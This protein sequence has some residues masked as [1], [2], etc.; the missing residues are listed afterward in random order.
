MTIHYLTAAFAAILVAEALIFAEMKFSKRRSA[1]CKAASLVFAVLFLLAYLWDNDAIYSV[2]DLA[3]IPGV[4]TVGTAGALIL[5]WFTAAAGIFLCL[6]PF[7]KK[8]CPSADLLLVFPVLVFALDAVFLNDFVAAHT[9]AALGAATAR[10]ALLAAEVGF[11]LGYSVFAL[12][13]NIG[14]L[15]AHIKSAGWMAL[16]LVGILLC[17]APNFTLQVLFDPNRY[18]AAKVE[19]LNLYHRLFIYPAAVI[20]IALYLL[21]GKRDLVTKRYVL[22]FYALAGLWN[23]MSLQ[24]FP[25][26]IGLEHVGNLPLHLCNTAL[27]VTPLCLTFKLKRVFY[28]TYFINVFGAFLALTIPNYSTE[29]LSGTVLMASTMHFY[30]PHYQ[31]FFMPLL[32]VALGIFERPRLRQFIW[33]MVGFLFYYV[34]M[35]VLNGWFTNYD[36]GVDFFFINS[37]FV[38]DKLGSWAEQLRNIVVQF[39]IGGLTFTYYPLYQSLYFLVY[40]LL[41]LAMW[42]LYEIAF[43]SVAGWRDLAARRKKIRMDRL[44][45][46]V[47]R[48]QD[49]QGGDTMNETETLSIRGFSKR[50]GTSDVYAV[51][52]VWLDVKGGEI[53]GFL[54]PNG[55]GKSTIIKSIVGIQPITEGSILVCGHD[56]EQESV[57]SKRCIGFV[58]DHYALYEKLTAREYVNYIADL[59]NVPKEERDARMAE[60]VEIF[61]LKKAVDEPISTYSHGMKQ[62]VAIMAA[63][64]HDPKVWILDE[65]LTGLDPN[66]IYQV[67][68]CMKRHAKAGNVVFF[69][70]HLIDIVERVCDRIAIIR[71]GQIQCVREVASIENETTLEEFYMNVITK[72]DVQAVPYTQSKKV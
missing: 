9:G 38:A 68:E 25:S 1:V 45:L 58:P 5:V 49:A 44:A 16:A 41:A 52:D 8:S 35:L 62:K 20:P 28:F 30:R 42:F 17:T 51:K 61:E 27:Y 47:S 46:E 13:K 18:I 59:Y 34:L 54:G 26:L 63:L 2:L 53:F 64:I 69:S 67:K 4:E 10:S 11:G 14:S 23:F 56:V 22:L 31:A 29:G 43:R 15:K 71:K 50:Y 70:S 57:A 24:K 33:S 55:A 36:A 19:D 40:C 48:A 7:F 65:P 66:S 72:G 37:D 6:H 39:E 3:P 12:V 32:I 21:L 60:F